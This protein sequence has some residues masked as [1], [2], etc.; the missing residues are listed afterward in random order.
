MHHFIQRNPL[1]AFI[2]L[3]YTIS[4]SFLYPSYRIIQENDGI[5]PLALI[6]LIGAY[7][8]SLAAII[9]QWVI[10]KKKVK[11]LLRSLIQVRAGFKLYAFVILFP[12]LLYLTVYALALLT[13]SESIQSHWTAGLSG[14]PIWFLLA[15]P[16]GPMGEELGWRGFMLPKLLEK[17][18]LIKS[19][20]I[21]GLAWGI[22]HLASF[23]FPGAAIPSFL[24]VNPWT[25]LLFIA[26]TI[27]LS[28]IY[29]YV[30][31]RSKGSIF[32][33]ILLHAFF[34]AA[35]NIAVDF[36]GETENN[37]VLIGAYVLNLILA[38][39]IGFVLIRTAKQK[40]TA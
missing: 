26:N 10:D 31:L 2:I 1:W 22:W 34:N 30:H 38:G 5:T 28:M 21:V 24:P 25:I 29:T 19:T 35:S 3:N 13:N 33:A 23:T 6:G 37:S 40:I 32:L 9:V 7:G 8:P 27:A 17:F 18:S 4:W 14:I 16:F 12:I 20:I 36:F 39:I 15:L 11:A